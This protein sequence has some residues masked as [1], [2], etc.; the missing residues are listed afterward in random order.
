M[1]P[2]GAPGEVPSPGHGL[3]LSL[4]QQVAAR[5]RSGARSKL[6]FSHFTSSRALRLC[7]VFATFPQLKD[8]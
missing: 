6:P 4:W 1:R 3:G 7:H 8:L 5:G 2:R